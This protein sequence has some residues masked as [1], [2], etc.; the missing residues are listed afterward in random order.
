[1]RCGEPEGS[2]GGAA[3]GALQLTAGIRSPGKD[4]AN[5]D[6][7]KRAEESDFDLRLK[8][9]R[10]EAGKQAEVIRRRTEDIRLLREE[11]ERRAEEQ[12]RISEAARN[13]AQWRQSGSQGAQGGPG[14]TQ[15]GGP[16]SSGVPE[17]QNSEEV[18]QTMHCSLWGIPMCGAVQA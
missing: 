12:K 11:E 2:A 18:W 13:E 16:E 14:K 3:V 10:A 4:A 8:A 6:E 17:A 7:R 1:M 9:A 5:H 15:N